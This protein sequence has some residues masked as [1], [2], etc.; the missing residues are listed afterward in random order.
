M[1]AN[2]LIHL[3]LL[4]AGAIFLG[5]LSLH[6]HAQQIVSPAQIFNTEYHKVRA[7]TLLSGLNHPW[8]LAFLPD[9][10]WLITGRKGTM[11][12]IEAGKSQRING[13]PS[14]TEHGQGGLLDVA[15]HPKYTENGWI[16]W[17]YNAGTFGQYGTE[18]A[19]GKLSKTSPPTMQNVQVL[20][21]MKPKYAADVHFGSRIAF[22]S[23]GYLYVTF[24]DRGD[25]PSQSTQQNA[26]QLNTHA[27]KSIRLLDDGRVPPDNPFVKTPNALPEIFTL[28]NRNMQGAARHPV[29]GKIW[30]HEH[31]PQGGDE[32][33][34]LESGVN[35]GWPVISYGV[36]YVIGTK[37][38]VG[39]AHPNMAQPL[40]HWTPS[41]APSGM[42][43]YTGNA[44]PK[45]QGNLFVGA[46]VKQML[47]RITLDGDQM[48]AQERLFEGELGR[49][50]DVRVGPDELIY[51]LTDSENGKLIRLEPVK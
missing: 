30:T 25:S 5:L 9:G 2:K 45:W 13:L 47:V 17:T 44:F 6:I 27:G 14:V 39:T 46:L 37:I 22:D 32:I 23:Q 41:I 7:V 36:N 35:Y 34:I 16:Y 8:A 40:L 26:Q 19:R 12:L 33:N 48:V 24:G 20:F 51:L 50:R 3:S 4:N 49:I 18:L 43:F 10:R 11:H 42:A 21:K 29:T 31:G 38:G 1:H 15:L 28:G